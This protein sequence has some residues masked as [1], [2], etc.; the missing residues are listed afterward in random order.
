MKT[1]QYSHPDYQ[2]WRWRATPIT[3]ENSASTASSDSQNDS[4]GDSANSEDLDLQLCSPC[5][6]TVRL[7]A[8]QGSNTRPGLA[9]AEMNIIELLTTGEIWTSLSYKPFNS[10]EDVMLV[11]E[12][13]Q[14][15]AVQRR[16]LQ[17]GELAS[18]EL[19]EAVSEHLQMLMQGNSPFRFCRRESLHP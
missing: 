16:Y 3:L 12:Q 10:N 18:L 15:G 14:Q 1:I 5:G 11:K 17:L 4:P 2:G 6:V 9:K 8:W 13:D 19:P 7:G